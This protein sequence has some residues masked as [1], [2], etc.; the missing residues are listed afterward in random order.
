MH[1]LEKETV[2]Q[3]CEKISNNIKSNMKPSETIGS[4]TVRTNSF[5]NEAEENNPK[6]NFMKMID[7]LKKEMINSLKEVEEGEAKIWLLER[8][9]LL[10]RP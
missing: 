1:Q 4:T 8:R 9:A 2:T 7:A 5:V 3:V 6:N 10:S